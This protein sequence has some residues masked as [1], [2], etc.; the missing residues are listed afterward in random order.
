MKI[1]ANEFIFWWY[2]FGY[3][4]YSWILS[5]Q[6]RLL[7]FRLTYLQRLTMQFTRI[8]S[9]HT[10]IFVR[11][12][13]A[14]YELAEKVRYRKEIKH[15]EE[16]FSFLFI[17]LKWISKL[18]LISRFLKTAQVFWIFNTMEKIDTCSRLADLPNTVLH[19]MMNP[20]CYYKKSRSQWWH[21][22]LFKR[23]QLWHTYW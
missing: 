10:R 21:L 19:E 5:H 13:C 17:Y 3:L 2:I 1:N 9:I 12:W 14:S 23:Y 6:N 15:D 11:T 20:Y 4:V 8:F 18:L 7:Y 16:L 22:I